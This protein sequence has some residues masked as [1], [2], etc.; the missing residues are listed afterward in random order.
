MPVRHTESFKGICQSEENRHE[1]Q[2]TK[3]HGPNVAQFR[4]M[5]WQAMPS[6]VVQR[7]AHLSVT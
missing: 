2:R 4:D 7:C 5:T 6:P 3:M 1:V